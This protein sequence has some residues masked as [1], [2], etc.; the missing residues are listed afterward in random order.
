[1]R[2]KRK[3]VFLYTLLAILFTIILAG[4]CRYFLIHSSLSQAQNQLAYT[5]KQTDVIFESLYQ[6]IDQ[7]ISDIISD[8]DVYEAIRILS[9]TKPNTDQRASDYQS[10][11]RSK[12]YTCYQASNFYRIVYFNTNGTV[13]F[14]ANDIFKGAID[15]IPDFSAEVLEK[16]A[17]QK[18]APFLLCV[19]TDNLYTSSDT[20]VFSALSKIQGEN[21]GYFI[22]QVEASVLDEIFNM[23][24]EY[25]TVSAFLNDNSLLFQSSKANQQ[26]ALEYV[27]D[28]K[29]DGIYMDHKYQQLTEILTSAGGT[30]LVFSTPLADIYASVFS[31]QFMMMFGIFCLF[32]LS[33]AFIF[34][35]ASKLTEPLKKIRKQLENTGLTNLESGIEVD[36]SVDEI[37]ALGSAYNDLSIRLSEAIEQEKKLSLLQLQSQFDAL[38][39]QVNPHFLYN[40][41]NVIN[42]RGL[43]NDDPVTCKLCTNLAAMLRYSSG[44][45][46]RFAS[47]KQEIEYVNH[48]AYLM[49]ARY[50]DRLQIHQNIEMEILDYQ[51]PKITI[52][53][54]VENSIKHGFQ[55]SISN[56]QIDIS[57]GI[58]T[59]GWYIAVQDNGQGISPDVCEELYCKFSALRQEIA[60]RKKNIDME[61]G[62]MG[63]P[64][65]YARL[66]F[67][68]RDEMTLL[69]ESPLSGGSKITIQIKRSDVK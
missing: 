16:A 15:H 47:V 33:L 64:S 13:I 40:V 30:K 45:I 14:S 20:L 39:A 43:E 58:L 32:L 49:Q 68:Y 17:R 42:T 29:E 46:N 48:Y 59:D 41:L 10:V 63:I 26:A 8:P 31:S 2:F 23:P 54:L 4:T 27:T 55:N 65:L 66:Y 62:Q 57:G 37:K 35:T 56:M 19:S 52:Q 1:M 9:T 24:Q 36:E 18:G 3:L 21:L 5:S 6:S 28:H 34:F 69:L 11:I 12:L 53:Q 60:D 25:M 38:Q 61:I 67:L 7:T 44:N 51:L 22:I 50:E